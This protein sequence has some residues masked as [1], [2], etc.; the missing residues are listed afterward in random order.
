MSK[1]M[2]GRIFPTYRAPHTVAP[3]EDAA[4]VFLD[5]ER[6]KSVFFITFVTVTQH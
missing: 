4:V 5:T 3:A 6:K 1:I 2:H